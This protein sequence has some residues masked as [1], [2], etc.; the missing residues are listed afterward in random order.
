MQGTA[1]IEEREEVGVEIGGVVPSVWCRL[2]PLS[3]W[4]WVA[5]LD[6]TDT[7]VSRSVNRMVPLVEPVE[8]EHTEGLL[9]MTQCGN[10][11]FSTKY[12]ICRYRINHVVRLSI[13]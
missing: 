12:G 13:L 6:S 7:G 8:G 2:V 11:L 9:R 3:R 4:F 5:L 1:R 10:S